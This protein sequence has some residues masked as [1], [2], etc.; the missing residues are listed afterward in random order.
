M[1]EST[2]ES[3]KTTQITSNSAFKYNLTTVQDILKTKAHSNSDNMSETQ[4]ILDVSQKE[5]W[6]I[7]YEG[8]D[9]Y[10]CQTESTPCKNLQTVLYRASDGAEIYVTSQTLSLDLVN[11][12][13]WYKMPFWGTQAM[14]ESCCLINSN[15]SYTLRSINGIKTN[16]ICS[17]KYFTFK[18]I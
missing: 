9:R 18:L 6:F 16:I 7:S 4:G 3:E 2:L 13:V 12:T 11:D 8:S 5:I 14:S 15:L 1:E 10:N 17:N